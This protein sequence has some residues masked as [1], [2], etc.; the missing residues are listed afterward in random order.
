MQERGGLSHAG[1]VWGQGCDMREAPGG[2]RNRRDAAGEWAVPAKGH[3]A[4][5]WGDESALQLGVMVVQ[6]WVPYDTQNCAF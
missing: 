4:S 6:P 2:P 5:F 3:G 1:A